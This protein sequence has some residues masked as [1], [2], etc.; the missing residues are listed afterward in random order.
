MAKSAHLQSCQNLAL[1]FPVLVELGI[2]TLDGTLI[3][4]PEGREVQLPV[5][6]IVVNKINPRSRD[7][8]DTF[9][10]LVAAAPNG[11]RKAIEVMITPENT[12]TNGDG[13]TRLRAAKV[14]GAEW[15]KCRF[16]PYQKPSDLII[17]QAVVN[18]VRAELNPLDLGPVLIDKMAEE[19][20]TLKQVAEKYHIPWNK[21]RTAYMLTARAIPEIRRELDGRKLFPAATG[22]KIAAFP[23]EHQPRILKAVEE[24]Y[25]R[26][27]R[28]SGG[29]PD[30]TQVDLI[31]SQTAE[32]LGAERTEKRGA[33][34]L[35]SGQRRVNMTITI[36]RQLADCLRSLQENPESLEEAH[37]LQALRE[38][39]ESC[40]SLGNRVL[41]LLRLKD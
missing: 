30:Q 26:Y 41:D 9:E 13:G 6:S 32:S 2:I 7:D 31:I 22:A 11:Y 19:G 38:E 39:I 3:E 24:E 36:A 29:S 17:H 27:H 21:A 12:L 28:K 35:H 8:T 40:C 20:L 10:N 5:A 4:Q 37:A 1:L 15:I 33:P 34:R 16:V 23:A 14:A 18:A 25:L